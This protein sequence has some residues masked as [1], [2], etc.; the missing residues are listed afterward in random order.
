MKLQEAL[1]TL[2]SLGYAHSVEA[3]LNGELV[4]G[5]YG[6]T[7]GGVFFGESMFSLADNA[8]KVAFVTLCKALNQFGY[9]LIDCQ[10]HTRMHLAVD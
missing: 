8:S 6:L 10:V 1:C 5:L 3:W 2:H 7:I 9:A 4:G